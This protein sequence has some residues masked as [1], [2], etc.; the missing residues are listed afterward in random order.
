MYKVSTVVKLRDTD[1]AGVLFFGNYFHIIHDAY[2][3]FLESIDFSMSYILNE[4]PVWLLIAH[5]EADYKKPLAVGDSTVIEIE[6][7][8][9]G[10]ASFTLKY[11]VRGSDGTLFAQLKT[12]HV[13]VDRKSRKSVR[14]PESIRDSLS[15]HLEE[16]G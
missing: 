8:T 12:T 14:L 13:A 2:E 10:K 4:S 16:P 9:I 6:V 1:A 5:A 15:A 7:G 3:A 11:R